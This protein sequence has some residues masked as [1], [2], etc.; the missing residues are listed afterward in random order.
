MR[1]EFFVNT[2]QH[3]FKIKTHFLTIHTAIVVSHIKKNLK[4]FL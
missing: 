4:G 3:V 2:L 1:L